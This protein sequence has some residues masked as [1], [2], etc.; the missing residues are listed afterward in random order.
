MADR[1]ISWSR[2]DAARA[3]GRAQEAAACTTRRS[4][5]CRTDDDLDGWTRAVLGAASVLPLRRRAGQAARPAVRRA[6]P[7]HRRRGPGPARGRA[8][9]L[10]GLRGPGL[11]G[12][13]VRGRGG[14]ARASAW[15]PRSCSPTASTPHSPRTGARTSSTCAGGLAG[16][17]DDVAAHVLDPDARLQAH[18]WGL[19]GGVRGAGRPGD[20]PADARPGAARRGVVPGA[21]LR[22]VAPADAR[23]AAR[24][25]RHRA[26][27]VELAAAAA[28]GPALPTPGWCSRPWT[29]RGGPVR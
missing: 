24:P 27:L 16:R 10:L 22:R 7:H 29:L 9:P 19:A 3:A 14:G 20:P 18:L 26:R 13:A 21:V 25:H 1:T 12:A 4:A 23:S 2:A 6:G 8:G 11:A 28:N 5:R 17:L 15:T